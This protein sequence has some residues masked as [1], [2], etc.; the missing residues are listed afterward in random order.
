MPVADRLNQGVERGPSRLLT[1]SEHG[2]HGTGHQ[3]RFGHRRQLGQPDPVAGAIQCLGRHV[4]RQPGLADPARPGDRDQPRPARYE[5][6]QLG[7]LGR[8]AHE[9]GCLRGQV[10]PQRRVVQRAQRAEIPRQPR[11]GHLQHPLRLGQVPQAV[12]A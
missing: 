8:P 2:G 12:L 5:R 4:Q 10:V 1:D 3:L 9:T 6:P 11:P 7:Q